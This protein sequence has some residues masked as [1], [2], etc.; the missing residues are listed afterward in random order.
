[1]SVQVIVFPRGQLAEADRERL[2]AKGVI[3]VEADDPSKVVTVLPSAP[4]Q[5]DELLVAAVSALNEHG[6]MG[7]QVAF[8]ERVG[9]LLAKRA[10]GR[11]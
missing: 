1:M 3:V 8:S 7:A 5:A 6:G 9:A 4:L 10:E 11:A 2:W